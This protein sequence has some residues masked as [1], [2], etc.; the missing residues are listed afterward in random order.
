MQT[1]TYILG[2]TS[3]VGTAFSHWECYN[4]TNGTASQPMNGSSITVPLASSLTCVAVY[5]VMNVLPNP[6]LALLSQ[7]PAA[8]P[9]TGATANLT[10]A[11]TGAVTASCVEAPSQRSY[12]FMNVTAPG[13]GFCF[14]HGTVAP[15][16]YI[17]TQAPAPG[18]LFERWLCYDI[19]NGTVSSPA[20]GSSIMLALNTSVTCV[21][22]YALLPTRPKLALL[23]DFPP[24]YIGPSGNLTAF[25]AGETCQKFPSPRVNATANVTVVHSNDGSCGNSS[26]FGTFP[27]GNYTLSQVGTTLFPCC[28]CLHVVASLDTAH[29]LVS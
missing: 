5:T 15:G 14:E 8:Y 26:T 4:V 21:A 28:A 25:T 23:S 7:Y 27:A 1:G 20:N 2:Q 18:T 10:A 13:A 16:K 22:E 9:A 12:G 24:Y 11:G 19:I 6:K 17:L 3:P 29:Q